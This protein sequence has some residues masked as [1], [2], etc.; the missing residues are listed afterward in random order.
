MTLSRGFVTDNDTT[1][2]LIRASNW[3]GDSVMTMPAVQHLRE[4]LPEAYI[5]HALPR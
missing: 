5:A 4:L 3:I 1:R 2:I